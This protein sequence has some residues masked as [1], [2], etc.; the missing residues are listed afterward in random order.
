MKSRITLRD[1][2]DQVGVSTA[3]VSQALSGKGRMAEPTR[4]R[5]LQVV[6]ELAYQPDQYAQNL[7]RRNTTQA[8]GKR[9]RPTKGRNV[10]P[11]GLL[12][13]YEVP[14]ILEVLLLE[15]QQRDEEGFEVSSYREQLETL[16]RPT[17][18]QL[19][20]LYSGLL[21]APL[22][23]DFHYDEPEALED[24][25]RARPDGPRQAP[26]VITSN[27]LYEKIHGAWLGRIAGCVLGRPLQMGWPKSKVVQ[28]LQLAG[29]Y[30]LEDYI[31][32][33]LSPPP[34]FDP[35]PDAAGAFLGEIHGAP[36]DDDTDFT[37]LTLY[38][39]ET[40]G[41]G[42]QTTDVAT[43][44]LS[45]LPYFGIHTAERVAYRNLVWNVHPEQAG[46]FLNPEREYVGGRTRADLYGYTA[47][48]K[49]ELA[50][51]QAFKDAAL[52]HTKNGVY[53]A[54]FVAAMLAWA[55]VTD[56]L[57]EIVRVGLSEIPRN[58]R[59]A[60]AVRTVLDG[61][62]DEGD[63]DRGHDWELAYERLLLDYGAYAP[64]HALNN[65]VWVI[66]ALLYGGGDIGRALGLAVACGMDTGSNAASVGSVMGLLYSGKQVP[67]RWVDPLEDTLCTALAHLPTSRISELARR[68]SV[69]A[70][71][72]VTG[73]V[74]RI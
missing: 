10:P 20:R 4:A 23:P 24:I 66:L 5:I 17:K 49:P 73:G 71:A 13:F 15:L 12:A 42:F 6:E 50:A 7:A 25:H 16:G 69:I 56:D 33:L 48:G 37:L 72:A 51:A 29:S 57:T 3:T 43:V 1:I 74:S 59:L 18:Q 55:F 45:H 46:T 64:I 32:R 8:G 22:R 26:V 14:Q 30:P 67:A 41:A 31:P 65:T 52:S 61:Y 70:E 54:M 21:S 36:C 53:A 62:G 39:L 19:Y 68:T 27:A 44:W 63:G 34:G 28:Y 40:Y 2:A 11:P 47:P 58:C 35:K 38:T 60:D 9:L